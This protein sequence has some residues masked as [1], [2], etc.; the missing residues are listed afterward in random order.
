MLCKLTFHDMREIDGP[1]QDWLKPFK[2]PFCHFD[3]YFTLKLQNTDESPWKGIL[4]EKQVPYLLKSYKHGLSLKK[5]LSVCA[6]AIHLIHFQDHSTRMLSW[7][8]YFP[9]QSR[10]TYLI[11]LLQSHGW[12]LG[13]FL[14][15]CLW[16]FFQK[17]QTMVESN[18]SNI[19]FRQK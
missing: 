12:P 3:L 2:L 1:F 8:D 11:V 19:I 10:H 5:E 13:A 17:G 7:V 4:H 14:E 9:F 18:S 15:G 6:K 16:F